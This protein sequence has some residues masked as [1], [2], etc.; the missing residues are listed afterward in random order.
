ACTGLPATTTGT[1]VASTDQ[2]LLTVPTGPITGRVVAWRLRVR[3]G[4]GLDYQILGLLRLG[5]EVSIVARNSR[6]T[7]YMIQLNEGTAWVSAY[8]I[9]ATRSAV[10]RLP[11][12]DDQPGTAP[13]VPVPSQLIPLVG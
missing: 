8:W 10:R 13:I 12:V 7:W 5:T 11:V 2:N 3:T 4:P 1:A 6:T 9:R